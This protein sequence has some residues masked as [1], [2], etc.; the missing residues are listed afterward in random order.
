M[1][2]G[3]LQLVAYGAQDVYLTGNP[4]ITYFKVVYRR[5]T[6][7]AM[8]TQEFPL[9]GTIDFGNSGISTLS[10]NGDLINK[11]YLRVI[12]SEVN[13]NGNNFA[14]TRRLGHAIIDNIEI[15]IG[16]TVIDRQYGT[17]IDIWYELARKGDHE[18]G[19]D[20]LIGDVDSMTAY[21]TNI[22]P[23][24]TIYLPFQ[25]WFNRNVGLSI[26]IIALQYH[27]LRINVRFNNLEQCIIRDQ[28]MDITG[29]TIE[30]ASLL[31]NYVF[32]DTEERRRFAQVGHEYLIE[33][34][35]FNG[36]E[37]VNQLIQRY[38]LD[39]N[40]PTKEIIWA[41]KNGNYTNGSSF[42]YYTNRDSW[43]K[44]DNKIPNSNTAL[45]DASIKII[46]ESV[47]VGID[48][49]NISG[50]DWIEVPPNSITSVGSINI[51]ND[52]LLN[53]YINN[54]SLSIGTYTITGK[55][56]VDIVVDSLNVVNC[57]N[58]VSGIT[59][60]DLS[61]PISQMTDTRYL[62]INPIVSQ[63][64][65]YGILIDGT[66]NPVSQAILYLNGHE[67][68]D[69]REGAYF[70]YVQSD[71]HHSNTPK[72][73]INVFSFSLFPEEHQPSGA[74]NLSRID[75]TVLENRY[76]DS[77]FSIGLPELNFLNADNLLYIFGTNYNILRVLS[78]MAAV[79]YTSV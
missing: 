44:K 58:V 45:I 26:P 27:D 54:N 29:I 40:F 78:G 62:P 42:I 76:I 16:G 46:K 28:N 39:Y 18:R 41:M 37:L 56:R 79:A 67:R 47:I 21:N 60:R 25:F 19:Y 64:N 55:I 52:S 59:V 15:S 13:P 35:Q 69:I 32:L 75:S 36:T 9:V 63:F 4:Q 2:G 49:S 61:I 30:N 17:W 31:V 57:F 24:Y 10:R 11:M 51:T 50:G 7:F 1:G 71:Q 66:V 77:T 43:T 70:N 23:Q 20:I 6:N 38:T 12:I 48:P 8:E 5:H 14:W 72:D 68:F 73:G 34:T 33:Q 74:A 65:N 53:V 22:K 3:L